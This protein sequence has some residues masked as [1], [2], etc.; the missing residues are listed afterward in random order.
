M[1][2]KST[3]VISTIDRINFKVDLFTR[4]EYTYKKVAKMLDFLHQRT[5]KDLYSH[6]DYQYNQEELRMILN[7]HLEDLD[8][9][10]TRF[11]EI[12]LRPVLKMIDNPSDKEEL[13]SEFSRKNSAPLDKFFSG[14]N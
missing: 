2:L 13:S 3:P 10:I 14:I 1:A 9:G 12:V 8:L 4:A 11:L 6:P 7:R 5:D